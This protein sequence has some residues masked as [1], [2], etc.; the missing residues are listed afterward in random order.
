EWS[1]YNSGNDFWGVWARYQ[2]EPRAPSL[3]QRIGASRRSLSS[4][5]GFL[6]P[7][8]HEQSHR[9]QGF[10]VAAHPTPLEV[11]QN[12][13]GYSGDSGYYGAPLKPPVGRRFIFVWSAGLLLF[14]GCYFGSKLIDRGRNVVGSILVVGCFC[15]F[16]GGL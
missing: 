11:G 1:T 13:N 16:A 12:S 3:N 5:F 2:N 8:L 10:F 4:R 15:A 7:F 14:P 6:Q 9:L